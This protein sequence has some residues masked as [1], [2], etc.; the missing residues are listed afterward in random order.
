[1][2]KK[3]Q[4][5]SKATFLS[6]KA[7]QLMLDGKNKKAIKNFLKSADLY[8]RIVTEFGDVDAWS[9]V[10]SNLV[11]AA[12]LL[13][14]EEKFTSAAKLQKRLGTINLTLQDYDTASDYF[15]V[16]TKY[17]LKDDDVESELLLQ[18]VTFYAFICY[19][20]A[21][22]NK[23]RE[24]LKRIIDIADFSQVKNHHL[25]NVLKSFYQSNLEG[26]K[27]SKSKL[28]QSGLESVEILLV[29]FAIRMRLLLEKSKFDFSLIQ[30]KNGKDYMEGEEIECK[31]SINLAGDDVLKTISEDVILNDV[32][33]E[34][35]ND[36]SIISKFNLPLNLPINGRD[37]ISQKFRSYYPGENEIGPL[38]LDLQLGDFS[39]KK[40]IEGIKFTV[41]GQP[42]NIIVNFE[43]EQEPLIGK[44]FP[45]RI[46]IKNESRG[47]ANSVDM[48]IQLPQGE[49]EDDL[50]IRLVRGAM[51]RKISKISAGELTSFLVQLK[52]T[53]EGTHIIKVIF[54]FLDDD[55][56]PVGP[57]VNEY[58]LE[59]NM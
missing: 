6:E 29:I 54:N 9:F 14:E 35:S 30:P 43:K 46:D 41:K 4:L 25:Y 21:E 15:N 57:L 19:L 52:P 7:N 48:E 38:L 10:V 42:A 34:K 16:A 40:R 26:I 22:Y 55:G 58:P 1:M 5:D 39:I 36:L 12:K 20:K 28:E 27:T 50:P 53:E 56:Q 24:F 2:K 3:N 59:I 51:S 11:N 18:S 44:S 23:G 31:L 49:D 8:E 45:L 47:D 32:I 37:E 33:V 17:A 13:L